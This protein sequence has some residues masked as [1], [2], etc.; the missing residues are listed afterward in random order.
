MAMNFT[1]GSSEELRVNGSQA[2]SLSTK[3]FSDQLIDDCLELGFRQL[4]DQ[5]SSAAQRVDL[6]HQ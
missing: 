2:E 6:Q 3:L 5:W 4:C 1:W